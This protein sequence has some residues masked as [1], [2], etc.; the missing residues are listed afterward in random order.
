MFCSVASQDVLQQLDAIETEI[1]AIETSGGVGEVLEDSGAPAGEPVRNHILGDVVITP[2][3]AADV[4]TERQ[5]ADA[6]LTPEERNTPILGEMGMPIAYVGFVFIPLVLGIVVFIVAAVLL[7]RTPRHKSASPS[8][9][10]ESLLHS[11]AVSEKS[12]GGAHPHHTAILVCIAIL[13]LVAT[14]AVAMGL[15]IPRPQTLPTNPNSATTARSLSTNAGLEAQAARLVR[16]FGGNLIKPA[17]Q[18]P[19]PRR[20]VHGLCVYKGAFEL[21]MD[22]M[23]SPF[24][25]L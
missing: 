15:F 7:S 19:A 21:F 3:D 25:G 5:R 18:C 22:W 13:T 8:S 1:N 20:Y 14:A 9:D 2:M 23:S 12:S 4:E 16:I 17:G 10:S 24:F 11:Q 6:F